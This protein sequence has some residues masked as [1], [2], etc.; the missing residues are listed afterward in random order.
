[1]ERIEDMA[2]RIEGI[3]PAG[4]TAELSAAMDRRLGDLAER[5]EALGSV[6]DP[7]TFAALE[8]RL[9]DL[10]ASVERRLERIGEATSGAVA[11]LGRIENTP[12]RH[13]PAVAAQ[14]AELATKIDQLMKAPPPA[15]EL[16]A[17]DIVEVR[18]EEIAARIGGIETATSGIA[19]GDLPATLQRIERKL[20]E[21][22]GGARI[23]ALEGHI[24]GL[25]TAI[26]RME[27]LAPEDADAMERD[28][29]A[30]REEVARLPETVSETVGEEFRTL[31]GRIEAALRAAPAMAAPSGEVETRLG[32][33]L[34]RLDA[35]GGD[36]NRLA[37]RAAEE[38]L[39]RFNGANG[40]AITGALKSLGTDL[41]DLRSEFTTSRVRDLDLLESVYETL[42]LLS[43]NLQKGTLPGLALA[44][45]D[46]EAESA[47]GPAPGGFCPATT[48]PG[49]RSSAALRPALPPAR[50]RFRPNRPGP[51]PMP[52]TIRAR[53]FST[54]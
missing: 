6:A 50:P 44:R 46:S 36:D 33:I 28:L 47:P 7:E 41:A 31:G 40:T 16:P 12:P 42:S 49:A 35:R 14:I 54:T 38:A 32:E 37:A 23:A 39:A 26:D 9:G 20:G 43:D 29:L 11:A 4:L 8:R 18:L 25:V 2:A 52:R 17:L 19:D 1:M 10:A 13:D 27:R 30:L 48:T 22:D 3:D 5:V 34:E 21:G 45:G 53:A 51:A 15:V 24:A